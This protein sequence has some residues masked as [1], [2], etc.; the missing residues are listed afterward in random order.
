[1]SFLRV[2]YKE[3]LSNFNELQS[4]KAAIQKQLESGSYNVQAIEVN[5]KVRMIKSNV[6]DCFHVYSS[7][8]FCITYK[9]HILSY[10]VSEE[11]AVKL[12]REI[13]RLEEENQCLR[14]VCT[15]KR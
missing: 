1:M 4:E 10:Q 2:K 5:M 12:T 15:S 14:W 6:R 3:L 7:C 9:W 13:Q 8:L 11:K